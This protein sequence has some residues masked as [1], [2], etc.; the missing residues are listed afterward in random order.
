MKMDDLSATAAAFIEMA[1]RIV[2]CSVATVDSRGRPRSRVMHPIWE[3]D[4]QA[5]VG[6]V[7][8]TRSPK[9]ADLARHAYV[10]CSY[11]ELTHDTCTAECRAEV[12][13]DD[14]ARA[15][16]WDLFTVT[17]E[18]LGFDPAAI[19]A[20]GWDA[21]DAPG[22]VVLR[23]RPWRLRVHPLS[24]VAGGGRPEQLRTLVWQE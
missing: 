24:V 11:W 22:F 17:P 19:G 4:G 20:P 8:T 2:W 14:A 15:R 1:H 18:P 7:G 5:L 16:V 3:W 10:S 6:W 12:V 13:T 21:P 9:L 23:L